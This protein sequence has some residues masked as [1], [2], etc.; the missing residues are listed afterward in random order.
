MAGANFLGARNDGG[1]SPHRGMQSS[2]CNEIGKRGG[3]YYS[4]R[5]LSRVCAGKLLRSDENMA[6]D[7]TT[8]TP[9]GYL[10]RTERGSDSVA[11]NL[12]NFLVVSFPP[13][14]CARSRPQG[15]K[16]QNKHDF[17]RFSTQQ[18]LLIQLAA[19][20]GAGNCLNI[21]QILRHYY[22]VHI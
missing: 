6:I 17:F 16:Q 20:L 19:T 5:R 8:C 11:C 10:F 21:R 14:G 12:P 1:R 4:S 18:R 15:C 7:L 9:V 22:Y 13:I 3:R 2:N